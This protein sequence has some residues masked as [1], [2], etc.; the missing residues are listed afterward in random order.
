MKVSA[1]LSAS[2]PLFTAVLAVPADLSAGDN[3]FI[4]E[5]P[6]D[7]TT[8]GWFHPYGRPFVMTYPKGTKFEDVVN[9]TTNFPDIAFNVHNT[10]PAPICVFGSSTNL[11]DSSYAKF[12]DKEVEGI[13]VRSNGTVRI[14]SIVPRGLGH[15]YNGIM[16][17]REGCNEKCDECSIPVAVSDTLLEWTVSQDGRFWFDISLGRLPPDTKKSMMLMN[18]VDGYNYNVNVSVMNVN[19]LC[20]KGARPRVCN[21]TLSEVQAICPPKNLW[22]SKDS[23]GCMSDCKRTNKPE[24]CAIGHGPYKPSSKFLK[25]LCPAAYSWAY[26]D[27]D[28]KSDVVDVCQDVI[29][30]N[31]I[32]SPIA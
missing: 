23:W 22:K 2:A 32:W 14:H 17:A 19:S 9:K 30:V 26:D 15:H 24:H 20:N 11:K 10:G 13:P 12:A 31:T 28:S 18:V 21:A 29:A 5:I 25:T 7:L 4:S 8:N 16:H 27:H 6:M 1:I 3:P